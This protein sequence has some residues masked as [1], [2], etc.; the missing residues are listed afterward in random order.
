MISLA[1]TALH[2]MVFE[3]SDEIAYSIQNYLLPGRWQSWFSSPIRFK[4]LKLKL[5]FKRLIHFHEP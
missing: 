2:G 3:E 4:I 5:V 1:E